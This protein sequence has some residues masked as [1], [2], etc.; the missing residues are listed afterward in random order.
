MFSLLNEYLFHWLI[1]AISTSWNE[2]LGY[3]ANADGTICV[4]SLTHLRFLFYV[5]RCGDWDTWFVCGGINY[6]I[7][8]VI[9]Q[10]IQMGWMLWS[11][12]EYWYDT[13]CS[14]CIYG[15]VID[16][17]SINLYDSRAF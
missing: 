10:R 14:V 3:F 17:W 6:L 5:I 7:N 11:S 4:F 8:N 2:S 16:V 15:I 1:K 13:K 9:L 12:F